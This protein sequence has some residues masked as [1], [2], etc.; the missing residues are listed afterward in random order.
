[1]KD[2]RFR[3]ITTGKLSPEGNKDRICQYFINKK[4]LSAS[5]AQSIFTGRPVTLAKN[6]D[7]EKAELIKKNFYKLGLI[8]D[9]RLQFN[10]TCLTNGLVDATTGAE[11]TQNESAGEFIRYTPSKINPA[12][13]LPKQESTITNNSGAIKQ[14]ISHHCSQ[15]NA[16]VLFIAGLYIA[17]GIENYVLRVLSLL[18][19]TNIV[20][21]ITGITLF[22][23]IAYLFPKFCQPRQLL[24]I[25]D[26]Q[27]NIL[28]V[29]E[30]MSFSFRQKLYIFRNEDGEIVGKMIRGRKESYLEDADGGQVYSTDSRITVADGA[31]N[32][33]DSVSGEF[34]SNT[35][36]GNAL[37]IIEFTKKAFSVL[38]KKNLNKPLSDTSGA[39]IFNSEGEH[40]ANFNN[41]Q[42]SIYIISPSLSDS[43]QQQ[44]IMF[45]WLVYARFML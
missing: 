3:L 6:L 1:M 9:I 4:G 24:T 13:F 30:V 16:L 41:E 43:D 19:D 32:F 23:A 17:L 42:A 10:S 7:W 37:N 22:I 38:S 18:I 34:I 25:R 33:A 21:T 2:E 26:G 14:I 20:V 44:L 11:P 39:P 8:A 31:S 45:G 28:I 36:V 12:L 5:N 15:W 35:S 40:I 27:K 29:E